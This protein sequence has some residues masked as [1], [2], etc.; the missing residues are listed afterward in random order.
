MRFFEKKAGAGC[1]S[2]TN[3]LYMKNFYLLYSPLLQITPQTGE[4]IA[5]SSFSGRVT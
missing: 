3:L 2:E 1:F 4:L 5:T